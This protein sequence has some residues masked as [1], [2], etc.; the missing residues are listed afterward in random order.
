MAMVS[1]TCL[2]VVEVALRL[3]DGYRLNRLVLQARNANP[4]EASSEGPDATQYANEITLDRST[5]PG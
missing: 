3:I 2:I 4:V 1:C 5:G